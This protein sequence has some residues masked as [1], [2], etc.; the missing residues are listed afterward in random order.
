MDRPSRHW[1]FHRHLLL[2][3]GRVIWN[4]KVSGE[5]PVNPKSKMLSQLPEAEAQK[6]FHLTDL[7]GASS[8]IIVSLPSSSSSHSFL[9]T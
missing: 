7:I 1:R 6:Y 3:Q 8:G 9:Q 4:K 5:P 2:D